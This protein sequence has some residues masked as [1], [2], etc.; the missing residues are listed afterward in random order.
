MNTR[1]WSGSSML[2][3]FFNFLHYNEFMLQKVKLIK[4]VLCCCSCIVITVSEQN[5][6][7]SR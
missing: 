2:L 1:Q 4:T 7:H 6:T 3:V 5:C